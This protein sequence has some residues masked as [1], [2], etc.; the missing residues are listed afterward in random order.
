MSNPLKQLCYRCSHR[1]HLQTKRRSLK[2][3]QWHPHE[4]LRPFSATSLRLA[5]DEDPQSLPS[6]AS[7]ALSSSNARETVRPITYAR[8]SAPMREETRRLLAVL[9]PE[10]HAEYDAL[11]PRLRRAAEQ[12]YALQEREDSREPTSAEK[13]EDDRDAAEFDKLFPADQVPKP[14]NDGF[15]AM[16][17][18]N[19]D[20]G[21]D[22]EVEDDDI[23][24]KAHGEL[25]QHREMRE[26]ARLGAWE[27][28]LL[29]NLA[30]PFEPPTAARPLRF[31]YTTY[32]GEQH[33]AARKVVVEF[34]PSDIPGLTE[35]QTAKL[36]KL[37]GPRYNPSTEIVRMSAENFETQAQNKRYLGDTIASLIAET[38]DPSADT[39]EDVPFDFRHHKSKPKLKFPE[40]WLL[41]E[42]RKAELEAKRRTREK[43]EAQRV[44]AGQ[45]A[46]GIRAIEEGRRIKVES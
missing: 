45:I 9:T 12:E 43:K 33:P 32:L 20:V 11:P 29:A 38:K 40:E 25:E 27:M 19:E 36:I 26:Y 16:G 24:T 21:P 10:G 7:P 34:T 30:R 13:E 6:R 17:E 46:D 1:A 31:R 28:P 2:S 5:N 4:L 8:P 18:E 22:D 35:Q 37:C 3:P 42:E 39:F 44:V 23:S 15:F 14:R 41:T